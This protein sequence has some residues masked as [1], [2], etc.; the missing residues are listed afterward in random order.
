[1]NV[2]DSR[3]LDPLIKES[4]REAQHATALKRIGGDYADRVSAVSTPLVA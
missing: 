2:F 1:M 3:T 4:L